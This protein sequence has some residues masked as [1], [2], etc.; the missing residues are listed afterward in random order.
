[1][2]WILTWL[3][4]SGMVHAQELSIDR[5]KE[6]E[7]YTQRVTLVHEYK[8]KVIGKRIDYDRN[9]SYQCVDLAKDWYSKLTKS[10]APAFNGSAYKAWKY[11][12]QWL[13]KTK[14]PLP[15]DLVFFKIYWRTA[16]HVG[17]FLF[18][19]WK[20][21]WVIDQNGGRWSGTWRSWDQARIAKYSKSIV[22]W[23]KTFMSE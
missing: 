1:M 14:T 10:L 15:W 5:V 20:Y 19:E 23:Y 9:G 4:L 13:V 8:E 22:L 12:V 7:M 21:I 3:V 16:W 6:I 2:I 11:W 17:V 18:E